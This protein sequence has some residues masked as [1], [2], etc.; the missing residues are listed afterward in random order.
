MKTTDPPTRNDIELPPA[1]HWPTVYMMAGIGGGL[2]V[3]LVAVAVIAAVQPA[4][5]T[6][7]SELVADVQPSLPP[8]AH[9]A[10]RP[11]APVLASPALANESSPQVWKPL[12]PHRDRPAPVP[13]K[14][15]I[16]APDLAAVLPPDV[17]RPTPRHVMQTYDAAA[18]PLSPPPLP[19][20]PSFTIVAS[21]HDYDE[22]ANLQAST[23]VLDL[24]TADGTSA[25]LLANAA[26]RAKEASARRNSTAAAEASTERTESI[27][28]LVAGRSDLA[29][30]PVRGESECSVPADEVRNMG[31]ISL[32]LRR[33]QA[34]PRRRPEWQDPD[35]PVGALVNAQDK[36]LISFLREKQQDWLTDKNA[37]VLTQM[38]WVETPAV[39]LHLTQMLACIKG[40][41][42]S[43]AL[44]RQ[45]LFDVSPAVREAAVQALKD[46]PSREYRQTLLDGFRYP[47]PPVAERA[48]GALT[49][50]GDHEAVRPLALM[51]DLPD[52]SAPT[53]EEKK[54]WSKAEV[55]KVNHLRN[56]LLC[57][58]AS[59]DTSDSVRGFIP[60]PGEEIPVVYY[61]QQKGDFV[62]ADVTYIQ[63]DFSVM[64]PVKDHGKWPLMQRFDYVVQ[65]RPLTDQEVVDM[66]DGSAEPPRFYPQREAVLSTLRKLTGADAGDS[67][68]AWLL[69]LNLREEA[70]MP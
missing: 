57:H 62:R 56:C 58:S 51:L 12:V 31:T 53:W 66:A 44:A 14:P 50:L 10:V 45:A 40:K 41:Q 18:Q 4:A 42:A 43:V 27:A 34:S 70:P 59:T 28:S 36:E 38:L 5:P 17:Q 39:R 15:M 1:M 6:T 29:G 3:V 54:G 37:P 25:K 48:G 52:P 8:P 21:K 7:P 16:Q 69:L 24:N 68:D 46:R 64:E 35:D 30:L 67:S 26:D 20:G 23:P 61:A 11:D 32:M 9:T 22:L 60:K 63:Q 65:R 47:W 19:A 49:V 2:A 33:A 13:A 55:V